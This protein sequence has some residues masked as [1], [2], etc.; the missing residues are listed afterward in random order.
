MLHS[1]QR[2][3]KLVSGFLKIKE[4]WKI[5]QNGFVLLLIKLRYLF[6][7]QPVHFFISCEFACTNK[8]EKKA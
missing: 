1:N 7:G 5:K 2:K 8:S 3:F 6:V 4:I